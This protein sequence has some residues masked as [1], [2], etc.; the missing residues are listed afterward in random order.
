MTPPPYLAADDRYEHH[1]YRRCG[2]VRAEAAGGLAGAVAQLR[3]RQADRDPAGDPAAGLRPRGDPLRPGQQLR[4]AVRRG[5]E[6]LR[7]DLRPGLQALPRRAGDLDQGRLRHVA[8]AVRRVGVA[9]VPARLARPEPGPDGPR[10]RRHLLQPPVRPGDA[11]RGDHGRARHGG[12]VRAGDVRRHLVVHRRAD[13]GGG[14]AAARDGRAAADPP[15][16]VLDAQPL[17]RGRPMD[18]SP[19]CSTCSAR[20]ASAASRSRRWRRGC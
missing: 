3:R 7:R 20:R 18:R 1:A 2:R 12:A 5:G 6:Q 10:P 17:G 14:R 16:V 9:Q 11:A 13:P 4:A 15:A 8:R 19:R